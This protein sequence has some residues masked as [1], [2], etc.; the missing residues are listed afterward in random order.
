MGLEENKKIAQMGGNSAKVARIDLEIKLNKNVISQK[1]KL[2]YK[3]TNNKNI[4]NKKS[5]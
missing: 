4:T 5:I 1:N 3:Y 2:N